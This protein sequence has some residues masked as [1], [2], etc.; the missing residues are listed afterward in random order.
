MIT[1]I[2][3]F[4]WQS[5][6]QE[7]IVVVVGV[8]VANYLL[9][10]IDRRRFGGWQVQITRNGQEITHR[11]VSARKAKDV[12]EESADLSVLLKGII[13]PYAHLNCDLITEG[14]ENGL[15]L[16]DKQSRRFLI[17]LDK[18]PAPKEPSPTVL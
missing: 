5:L 1:E 8:L 2:L 4:I 17:N 18:N 12:L 16:V 15:L 7:F 9:A 11:D 10:A 6:L 14:Q 3:Q 13:S